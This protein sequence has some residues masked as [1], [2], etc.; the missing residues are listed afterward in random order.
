V[1]FVSVD[2]KEFNVTVSPSEAT[3][4]RGH[5][6]AENKELMDETS[7]KTRQNAAFV[8]KYRFWRT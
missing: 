3:L 2:S 4:T 1:F 6:S 7:A 8:W 5:G